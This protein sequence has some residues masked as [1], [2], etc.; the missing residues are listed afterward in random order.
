MVHRPV[1]EMKGLFPRRLGF[2]NIPDPLSP[3][4]PSYDL[5]RLKNLISPHAVQ[6]IICA[7]DG[8]GFS[9]DLQECIDVLPAAGGSVYVKPDNYVFTTSIKLPSN[10]HLFGSGK[11]S[12][13]IAGADIDILV[14]DSP[15]GGNDSIFIDS[16]N[17]TGFGSGTGSGIKLTNVQDSILGNCAHALCGYGLYLDSCSR[18]GVQNISGAYAMKNA[19]RFDDCEIISVNGLVALVSTESGIYLLRCNG[20]AFTAVAP[21]YNI[22]HGIL[23]ES[24]VGCNFNAITCWDNDFLNTEAFDG[25]HLKGTGANPCNYN[26]VIAGTFNNNDRYEIRIN[27]SDCNENIILGNDTKGSDHVGAISDAGTSTVV[28]HNV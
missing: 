11:G 7:A 17:F 4:I 18:M 9:T 16:F 14:N 19:L 8:T 20:I 1:P 3:D 22:K 15:V 25:I 5:L 21:R 24:C 10:I 26:R 23:L 28:Q 6:A 12:N 27:D 2:P 13:L